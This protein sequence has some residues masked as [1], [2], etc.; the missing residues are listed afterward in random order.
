MPIV[1]Y[2]TGKIFHSQVYSSLHGLLYHL[3]PYLPRE[4]F[5]IFFLIWFSLVLDC[6]NQFIF[7]WRY[8]CD[9]KQ[10][11]NVIR[12]VIKVN[13]DSFMLVAYFSLVCIFELLCLIH[14]IVSFKKKTGLSTNTFFFSLKVFKI[15]FNVFLYQLTICKANCKRNNNNS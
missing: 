13:N 10:S 7:N 5:S 6:N 11:L 12:M 3:I 1:K 8:R 9:S 4:G 15:L 14:L 2:F